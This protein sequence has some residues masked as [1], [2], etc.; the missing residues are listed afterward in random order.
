MLL[1]CAIVFDKAVAS[2][3]WLALMC[4]PL[5]VPQDEYMKGISSW[6]FDVTALKAQARIGD[7]QATGP[8]S[9]PYL[10]YLYRPYPRHELL[11][12]QKP[13]P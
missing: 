11:A 10:T 7:S 5:P 1:S 13:R 3:V 2:G 9:L 6:N 12:A 8:L 4:I